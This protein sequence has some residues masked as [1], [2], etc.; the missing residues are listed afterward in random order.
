MPPSAIGRN[1]PRREARDKVTGRARY[2]DD[3]SLPGM[4]HGITVRSSCPRGRVKSIEY[5][6][7]PPWDEIVVVTAKD[8][9]GTNVIALI[10]DDQPCLADGVVNHPEEPIVLLAHPD[11][12]VLEAARLAV[13]IEYEPLPAVFTIEAAL[14]KQHVIWGA[15]NIFKEYS[16]AKGDVER[17]LRDPDVVVV[18]GVYETGAQEQ[19]YI[20]NNGM[21]ATYSDADGAT[22]RG[23]MQCPYYIQKA[24]MKL[25]TWRPRRRASSSSRRAA[26]SAA[27]KSIRR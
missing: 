21:I 26:G 18:H 16:I 7:G 13:R 9:P 14:A 6:P 8:I 3:V 4:I 17:A 22:V 23:S 5:L 12:Q 24:L 19:L 2:V 15:D 20:E 11:R 25:S 10:V 1:V 27:K